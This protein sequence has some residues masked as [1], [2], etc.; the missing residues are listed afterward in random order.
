M[1]INIKNSADMNIKL[2]PSVYTM[3]WFLT[4]IEPNKFTI[5]TATIQ[6]N[7]VN[8]ILPGY[9]IVFGE[10]KRKIFNEA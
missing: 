5:K 4:G 6:L 1:S 10:A 9:K 8:A 2:D 7:E 3:F